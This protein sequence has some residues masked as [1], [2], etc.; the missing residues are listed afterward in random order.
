MTRIPDYLMDSVIHQTQETRTEEM[1][2]PD[3]AEAGL[4]G[5]ASAKATSGSFSA[6]RPE[7]E[8]AVRPMGYISNLYNRDLSD[9]ND[10]KQLGILPSKQLDLE[11][12]NLLDKGIQLEQLKNDQWH[13][14]PGRTD[15]VKDERMGQIKE[16]AKVQKFGVVGVCSKAID[17]ADEAVLWA[18]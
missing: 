8:F 2:L 6:A 16:S 4:P 14:R 7:E 12:L 3:Q 15:E 11:V 17:R 10:P 9:M 1:T 18:A 5:D 13:S